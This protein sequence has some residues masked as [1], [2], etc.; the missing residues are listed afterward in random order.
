MDGEADQHGDAI[1]AADASLL[2]LPPYDGPCGLRVSDRIG[3]GSVAAMY[4]AS[5]LQ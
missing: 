2:Y 5:D 3:D 4:T 1:E